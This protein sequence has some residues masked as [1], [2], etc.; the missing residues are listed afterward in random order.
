MRSFVKHL[1][2]R[3]ALHKNKKSKLRW[4]TPLQAMGYFRAPAPNAVKQDNKR[5]FLV[6]IIGI[7]D[8][9]LETIKNEII[10]S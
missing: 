7:V 5:V 6:L 1:S 10:G 8:L 9:V 4:C 2:T 3:S